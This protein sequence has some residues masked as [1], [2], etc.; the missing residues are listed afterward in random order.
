DTY[1]T[2]VK[3]V[4]DPNYSVSGEYCITNS[5]PIY[6]DAYD[7]GCC[8]NLTVEYAVDGGTYTPITVPYIFNFS[9]YLDGVH[10]LSIKAYDCLG[11]VSYDNE[12]FYVD[13]SYPAIT[14]IV[15]DPNVTGSGTPDYW[16]TTMTPIT[17]NAS[18]AGPCSSL[19]V[20]IST[21]GVSWTM[22]TVPYIFHFTEECYHTLYI[23]AYD[24]LGHVSYDNETFNVD[25][26]S[27][28]VNKTIVG[29]G[30]NDGSNYYVNQSAVIY[31]N[32]T[33]L[34]D[35]AVG[36]WT[37][38][39]RIWWNGS[40]IT[41]VMAHT[42][43]SFSFAHDCKHYLEYYVN[44]SLGN[45]WP[46]TGWH[47]ETFFVD[48]V[49]PTSTLVVGDPKYPHDQTATYVTTHTNLTI[50]GSDD[51]ENCSQGT[52]TWI[53]HYRIWHNGWGPEHIGNVWETLNTTFTDECVNY[54]EYWAT[55]L[56]GNEEAHH[57]RTFYVDDTPPYISLNVGSPNVPSGSDYYVTLDTPVSLNATD[58]GLTPQ[59]T[60]GVFTI[61]Y[62]IWFNETW[63]PWTASNTNVSI[64]F[65]ENCTHYLEYWVEDEL[66]NRNPTSGVYNTTFYVGGGLPTVSLE[67]G[68]PNCGDYITKDTPI[69]INATGLPQHSNF[70]IYYNITNE[71]G[72]TYTGWLNGPWNENVTFTFAGLGI[73]DNC[74]HI[75]YY[76][77]TDGLGHWE[78]HNYTVHV[79]NIN[80]TINMN[81]GSPKYGSYVTS[82]TPFWINA[83]DDT[84]ASGITEIHYNI[85]Y[86]GIW[87]NYVSTANV[88]FTF[89]GFAWNGECNHTIVTWAVDCL[90]H[91]SNHITQTYYEDDSAPTGVKEIGNPQYNGGEFVTQHTPIW[92]NATDAGC[93]GGVGTY[94]LK[95]AIGLD[96]DNDNVV[97]SETV[98]YITD[99][100]IDDGDAN[101]GEISYLF[102]IPEDC[103]HRIRWQMQDYLGT[104]S[105]WEGYQWHYVDTV[106][107]TSSIEVGSP[108]CEISS[109]EYCVTTSTP[110]WINATDN[111]T[112]SWCTVGSYTIHWVIWNSTGIYDQGTSSDINVSLTIGEECNHT[113]GYWVEDDLG[114]RWPSVGY[115]NITIHVDDTY[116][117]IVKTVGDPNYSVS[118]E[119]YVT[120]STPITIDAYDTGCCANMTVEYR[121]WYGGIWSGWTTITVPQTIYLTGE[122]KHYLEIKAYDCLGHVTL[123]NETFYVDEIAP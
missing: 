76:N 55:D 86:N 40:W 15:G 28:V 45:R 109:T 91:E 26:S 98:K 11:H 33:D 60:V 78:E 23:K 90:G 64:D 10:T 122:C 75:I 56:A 103:H 14:K 4:G 95:V 114:N 89:G 118:G 36:G 1:P 110:I 106:A 107:P 57:N 38:H 85:L 21:D 82:S 32:V 123:D 68:S 8:N 7:N 58:N 121:I 94:R 41:D 101:F 111:G 74:T 104:W 13:D 17:I 44:D 99:G 62:R 88:T 69:Y 35:C 71:T 77:I 42:N 105:S 46:A 117:T 12:T 96:T 113:L 67:L 66:G 37:L 70:V 34:P 112:E 102:Y 22:I 100:S 20:E 25:D 116:P 84:C 29:G 81:V 59:C 31:L 53:V 2:I 18:D 80:P 3:T 72:V 27:P 79:D 120:T 49:A 43:Q 119:Y 47:N 108:N 24:C 63:T 61:H 92:I 19:Y 9:S 52:G 39:Y 97:D 65:T 54:I 6:I 73:Y 16:V 30:Y 50:Y 83:S 115:Y 51:D 93:N 5:T 48:S 87:H